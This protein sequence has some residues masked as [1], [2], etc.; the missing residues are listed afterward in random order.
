MVFFFNKKVDRILQDG[1][2]IASGAYLQ[3]AAGGGVVQLLRCLC[4]VAGQFLK[5]DHD[6]K[7]LQEKRWFE[8]A[9]SLRDGRRGDPSTQESV[10]I[11]GPEVVVFCPIGGGATATVLI[12]GWWILQGVSNE[13]Q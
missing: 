1:E 13:S 11:V 5:N 9:L 10:G 7:L 6:F 2:P 3:V 12:L 8:I 4:A